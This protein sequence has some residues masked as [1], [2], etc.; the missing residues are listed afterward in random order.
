MSDKDL[1]FS[2]TGSFGTSDVKK[3]EQIKS[4]LMDLL[5]DLTINVKDAGIQSDIFNFKQEVND[6]LTAYVLES[7]LDDKMNIIIKQMKEDETIPTITNQELEDYKNEIARLETIVQGTTGGTGSDLNSGGIQGYVN[8]TVIP[9]IASWSSKA[10]NY[11]S[12]G[13]R[14]TAIEKIM[15]NLDYDTINN[16][17]TSLETWQGTLKNLK[18]T[19]QSSLV[20][21]INELFQSASDGKSSIANAITG[22]GIS[23]DSNP[24]YSQLVDAISKLELINASSITIDPISDAGSTKT[25]DSGSYYDKVIIS[26]LPDTVVDISGSDELSEDIINQ[27]IAIIPKGSVAFINGTKVTGTATT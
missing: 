4:I 6:K 18:T 7:E 23:L 21:A 5:T 8:N 11:D 10:D 9:Q 15:A 3:V 24:T 26:S 1:S 25:P 14:L 12:Y 17:L 2:T 22:K 16:R 19:D 27:I 13:N 20:N